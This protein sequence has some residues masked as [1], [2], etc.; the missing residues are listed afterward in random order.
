MAFDPLAAGQHFE[1]GAIKAASGPLVEV[2]R[3]R[4]LPQPGKAQP[5]GQSFAVAL[6]RLAVDQHGQPVLE[7]EVGGIGVSPLLFE[8]PCH[9]GKPEFAQAV[10]GGVGQHH[11]SPQW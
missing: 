7:A 1:Q 3:R 10:R 9:A 5:G 4:L 11:R 8:R 6:Q 2:L